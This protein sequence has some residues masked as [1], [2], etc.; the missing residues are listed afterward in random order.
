[1]LHEELQEIEA[2]LLPLLEALEPGPPRTR[3]LLRRIGEKALLP[4]SPWSLTLL[5]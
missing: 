4:S 5:L 1:V 3:E 2:P